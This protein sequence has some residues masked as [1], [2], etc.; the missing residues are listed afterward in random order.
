MNRIPIYIISGFLGSGKTRLL[1]R[2]L[3]HAPKSA[4]IINEFGATAIDQQLLREHKVPLSTLVG[5]CLCCQ[6]RG[7][8]API[9]K[10]LRMAWDADNSY[11]ER[12]II[13]TSGVANPEPVLDILFMDRW[14]SARY[15]LQGA[16]ATV[17]AIMDEQNFER[18]PEVVAQ[19]AWADTVVLT[20]TDLAQ[21]WQ[22]KQIQTKLDQLAPIATRLIAV[23][24]AID[25]DVIFNATKKF[26]PRRNHY[27]SELPQHE[28]SSISIHLETPIAWEQ[29]HT[30]LMQLITRYGQQL[31]RLKGVVYTPEQKQPL[32]VQG[33]AEKLYPSIRLPSRPSDDGIGRLVFI[34]HGEIKGLS[35]TLQ[36]LLQ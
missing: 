34:S 9:L 11:F 6:V 18:F 13:E 14:L 21:A 35:E 2:L 27:V 4:V 7:S 28:F 22:Q 1:N 17:S 23:Q 10:N 36:A 3:S 33:V 5:G 16:I 24:G 26:R 19:I 25:P 8:L 32:L 30:A 29:L 15:S 31:V 20:Q 12:V